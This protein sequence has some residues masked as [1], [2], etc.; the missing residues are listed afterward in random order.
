MH[1]KIPLKMDR[2]YAELQRIKK[3]RDQLREA[4]AEVAARIEGDLCQTVRD[5]INGPAD[6]NDVYDGA[7]NIERIARAALNATEES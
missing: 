3:Q 4:L 5:V 7:E 2:E 6:A 1:W